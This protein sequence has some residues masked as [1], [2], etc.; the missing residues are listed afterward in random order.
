M[1]PYFVTILYRT[2]CACSSWSVNIVARDIE[3]A[4]AIARAK[5]RRR[6]PSLSRIDSIEVRA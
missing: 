5:L 3:H 6:S 2:R 1:H 4:E